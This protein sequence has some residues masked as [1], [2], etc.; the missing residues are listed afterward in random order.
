M[1]GPSKLDMRN[2][3]EA[4]LGRAGMLYEIECGR[5][6]FAPQMH[7]DYHHGES[8]SIVYGFSAGINFR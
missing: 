2:M 1:R 4:T 3:E 6:T 8:N 5:F 7:W